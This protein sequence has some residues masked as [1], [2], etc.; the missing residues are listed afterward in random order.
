MFP[1]EEKVLAG[2]GRSLLAK[3]QT[4]AIAESVTT[5]LI[6]AA[7]GSTT[8]AMKFYQGGIT[9][10]NIAQKFKHLGVEPIHADKCDAVSAKVAAEMAIGVSILFGSHWG[11]GITGFASPV[12]ESD[13]KLFAYYAIAFNQTIISDRMIRPKT[14]PTEE[15]QALYVNTVLADLRKQIASQ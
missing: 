9:V 10:Y 5:G 11:I 3:D 1:F 8:D 12:P 13:N 4:I 2:I 7:I 15:I 14:G 6:Q